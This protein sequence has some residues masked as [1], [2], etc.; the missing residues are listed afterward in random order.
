MTVYIPIAAIEA[1]KNLQDVTT[2][3]AKKPAKPERWVKLE[4]PEVDHG[5][6]TAPQGK[7]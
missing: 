5:Q 7:A 3:V 2:V 6:K 4:I 1:L